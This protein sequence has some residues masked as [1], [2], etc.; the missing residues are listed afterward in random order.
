MLNGLMITLAFLAMPGELEFVIEDGAR[1]G[2]SQESTTESDVNVSEKNNAASIPTLEFHVYDN[3]IDLTDRF[4]VWLGPNSGGIQ[5]LRGGAIA[6]TE[7]KEPD[8]IDPSVKLYMRD[9]PI[10]FFLPTGDL[11]AQ[12]QSVWQYR[13]CEYRVQQKE[14]VSIGI[15]PTGEI[16]ED[17]AAWSGI[18]ESRCKDSPNSVAWYYYGIYSGLRAI[19]IG[20]TNTTGEGEAESR[21][22]QNKTYVLNGT[23]GFG[24]FRRK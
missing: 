5:T 20:E 12:S 7:V 18:I 6:G 17:E 13:K 10:R 22:R 14:D 16:Y 21:F 24:A 3:A 2:V 15:K 19:T 8:D 4:T 9:G 11:K 23:P 1:Q